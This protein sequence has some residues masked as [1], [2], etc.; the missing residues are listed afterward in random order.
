MIQGAQK[1]D[2]M[3]RQQTSSQQQDKL[4]NQILNNT[5]LLLDAPYREKLIEKDQLSS[6]PQADT[7]Q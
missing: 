6:L 3:T 5:K 2:V 1:G 7:H 4:L